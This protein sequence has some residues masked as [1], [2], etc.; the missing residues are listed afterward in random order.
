[1]KNLLKKIAL[2]LTLL[3]SIN[4]IPVFALT[5]NSDEIIIFEEEII[6]TPE[7]INKLKEMQKINKMSRSFSTDYTTYVQ[8]SVSKQEAIAIKNAYNSVVG[9]VGTAGDV[10]TVSTWVSYLLTQSKY[11][12]IKSFLTKAGSW[13]GNIVSVMSFVGGMSIA[14]FSN[15][16]QNA[17]DKMNNNDRLIFRIDSYNLQ[18]SAGARFSLRIQR[19]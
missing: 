3:L 6:L 12:N 11:S 1:M 2:T 15:Q 10:V 4:T 16:I 14:R 18:D 9:K 17:L 7:Q 8:K 13:G 5:N 19:R